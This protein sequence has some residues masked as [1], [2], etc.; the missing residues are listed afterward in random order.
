MSM[1]FREPGAFSVQRLVGGRAQQ[2]VVAG[3]SA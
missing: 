1:C 3:R 2:G